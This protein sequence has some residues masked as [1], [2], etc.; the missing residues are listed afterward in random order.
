M[1]K[2][3]AFRYHGAK[4]RL[5]PWIMTFFPAH[6]VY[7]EPFGGAA[8]VLIQKERSYSE[9]Y[10][11]LDGDVANFFRVIRDREQREELIEQVIFTPYAREEFENAFLPADNPVERARR[12]VIRAQMGFG[13]AGATKGKTGFRSDTLRLYGTASHLWARYPETLSALGERLSG[14]MIENR[15]ALDVIRD[16]DSPNTLF[17]VDPPYV[18]STRKMSTGNSY[19]NHEMTD[20][21]HKELILKLRTLSGMVILSGYDCKL[22]DQDLHGWDKYSTDSRISAARG[23]TTRQENVWLNPAASA[24]LCKTCSR[25]RSLFE[26]AA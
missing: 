11:D 8:G 14:V 12:L 9:V 17:F 10:N 2:S 4:F 3:P 25:Q 15:P 26:D 19:Y 22:Y 7:V 21:D 24:A 23:C 18:T 16:Q 5:A 1:I 13:S 20:I 6:L